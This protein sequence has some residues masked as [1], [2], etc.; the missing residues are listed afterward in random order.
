MLLLK[1]LQCFPSKTI[2][3]FW[4][5]LRV[6]KEHRDR[7]LQLRSTILEL[8]NTEA[9][10][11]IST[12]SW[13]QLYA[14]SKWPTN[15]YKLNCIWDPWISL[16]AFLMLRCFHRGRQGCRD[17]TQNF[18]LRIPPVL[19]TVVNHL[20]QELFIVK[21]SLKSRHEFKV[22]L[23]AHT[24]QPLVLLHQIITHF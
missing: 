21:F 14:V 7:M 15:H 20:L 11:H 23:Q 8:V 19:P 18:L 2:Q 5:G 22:L 4:I 12:I 13:E 17:K 24:H 6:W 16:P 10:K 9:L 1:F 3:S